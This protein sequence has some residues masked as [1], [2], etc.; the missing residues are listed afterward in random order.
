MFTSVRDLLFMPTLKPLAWKHTGVRRAKPVV[1][2]LMKPQVGSENPLVISPST[3]VMPT[4]HSRTWDTD[5][6]NVSMNFIGPITDPA[7]PLH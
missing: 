6:Q 4:S 2:V 7:F 3:Y 1:N 5:D